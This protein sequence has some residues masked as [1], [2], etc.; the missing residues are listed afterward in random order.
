VWDVP[1][2]IAEQSVSRLLRPDD[3]D[4]NIVTIV[5]CG[6]VHRRECPKTPEAIGM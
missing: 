5:C 1:I 3:P 6:S 2:I 4:E